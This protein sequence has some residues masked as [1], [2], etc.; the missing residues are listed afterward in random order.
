MRLK[1]RGDIAADWTSANP[2]LLERE[3]GLEMDTKKA[4]VGDGVTHWNDLEYFFF[5]AVPVVMTQA[6]YDSLTPPDPDTI[7]YIVG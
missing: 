5:Q 2:V 3:M 7:Y 6:A 4:K 1:M